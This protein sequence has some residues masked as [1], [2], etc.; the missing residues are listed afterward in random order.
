MASMVGVVGGDVAVFLGAK[1][2]TSLVLKNGAEMV[3]TTEMEP[4]SF[5]VPP[6][7]ATRVELGEH[8]APPLR[9]SNIA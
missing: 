8:M 3:A 7:A 9:V 4:N 5:V 6:A 1:V 2:V